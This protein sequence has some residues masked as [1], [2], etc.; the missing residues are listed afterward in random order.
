MRKEKDG[1]A[2]GLWIGFEGGV[3]VDEAGLLIF[4]DFEFI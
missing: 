3:V 2:G 1:L 4:I